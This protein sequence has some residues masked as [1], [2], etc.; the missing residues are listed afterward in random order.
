MDRI[1]L[2]TAHNARGPEQSI[3][4][5]SQWEVIEVFGRENAARLEKGETIE[6]SEHLDAV[7]LLGFYN[8]NKKA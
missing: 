8:A 3:Q 1:I 7:D 6:V 5:Y 2:Y 4:R